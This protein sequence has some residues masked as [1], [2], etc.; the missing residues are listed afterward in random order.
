MYYYMEYRLTLATQRFH[1]V[2][3]TTTNTAVTGK[4]DP[5]GKID[6]AHRHV[7]VI[8]PQ[9]RLSVVFFD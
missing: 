5:P 8:F 4:I 9:T 3:A 6:P 2:I 7:F 1:G